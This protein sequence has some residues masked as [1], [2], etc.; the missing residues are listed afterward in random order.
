MRGTHPSTTTIAPTEETPYTSV[1]TA[2]G[3]D[4]NEQR[5]NQVEPPRR[6]QRTREASQEDASASARHFFASVNGQ[7]QVVTSEPPEEVPTVTAEGA[8]AITSTIPTTSATTIVTG[9]EAGSPRT[10]LPNGSPSRSTSTVTC[11]PQKMVKSVSEGWTNGPPPDGTDSAD[12]S[13]SGSSLLEEGVPENLGHDWRVLYPFEIPGVRF[14]TDNTPPNQRRLAENDSLVELIQT[15]EYLEDTP[16]WGWRD[17]QFYTQGM[18][19]LFYRERGRGRGRGR[20]GRERIGER[21]FEREAIQG[22][23]RGSFHGNGR[24]NGRG[25]Y[26]QAPLERN[27]RDRQEEEWSSPASDERGRRDVPVSSPAIQ[28]SQQRTPPTPAPSEDRFFM[29][30]SS[31]RMGSPLVRMSPQSIS[32]RKRGQDINQT[33]IQTSQPGSTPTQMGV[34]DN[35]LHEDLPSTTPLA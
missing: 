26:T 5:S 27:Q 8:T 10:F 16:M 20:G 30:W 17:Y 6:I 22:F 21:P 29:D 25:F 11:R 7:N 28:E 19:I 23:G 32:V 18:V 24:G 35:I 31:I 2:P 15:T 1:K 9:S 33:T 12:S 3:R 4:S 14:P 34:T 13:L